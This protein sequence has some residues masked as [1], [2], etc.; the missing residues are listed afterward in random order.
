MKLHGTDLAIIG[1]IAAAAVFT[2][3][4]TWN[5]IDYLVSLFR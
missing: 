3:V 2:A 5:A 1:F 4:M